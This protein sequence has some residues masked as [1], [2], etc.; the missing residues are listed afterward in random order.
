MIVREMTIADIDDVLKIEQS[1]FPDPW[2][3]ESFLSAI[4]SNTQVFVVGE[5]DG[6]IVGFCGASFVLEQADIINIAVSTE[7]QGR[8]FG[9]MMLSHLL[10]FLEGACVDNIM[11]E[12]RVSNER[13][14]A[15][16]QWFCFV[17]YGMRKEYYYDGEDALVMR[18]EFS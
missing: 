5:I 15:L 9:K 13:A 4:S 12:V 17:D 16:Y 14:I 3:R 11:L 8:S 7:Y 10:H 2:S 18:K 1:I 6:R